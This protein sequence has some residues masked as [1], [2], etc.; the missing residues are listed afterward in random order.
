MTLRHIR[1]APWLVA[2]GLA[3]AAAPAGAT[4]G[5]PGGGQALPEPLRPVTIQPAPAPP[6]ARS[7]RPRVLRARVVPRRIRAG[8]RSRLRIALAA[9]GR[10]RIVITR[11]KPGHRVRVFS[12]TVTARTRTL[13]LRLPAFRR[14]GRYRVTVIAMDGQGTRS[15]AVRRS[16]MVVH[17]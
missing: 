12:R 16:L 14:T 10:V 13:V 5:P 15:R 17:R 9:P 11:G 1:W 6:S 3:V 8:H 2:A 4:E 7:L